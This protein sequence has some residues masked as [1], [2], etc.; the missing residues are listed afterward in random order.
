MRPGD[1]PEFFRFPPP[2]GQARESTIVLDAQGQFWH[3]GAKVERRA[4]A[5]AFASWLRRHPDDE[6]WILSNGYD[7]TYLDVQGT[8][9]FVEGLREHGD[10]VRAVLSDGS[11]EPLDVESLRIVEDD[12]LLVRV[13]SQSFDAKFSRT[14]QLELGPWL[15]TA[16]DGTLVV[17]I[18][19]K[20]YPIAG[21]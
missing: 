13:K 12:V 9:Y 17:E 15:D 8:P 7:W 5:R 18:A 11:E 1:H 3:D 19:G 2:K 4:M 16:A 14:A 21:K 10:A 20:T 6:R